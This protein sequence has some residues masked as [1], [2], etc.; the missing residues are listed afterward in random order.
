MT[1]PI[2]PTT[3]MSHA[4]RRAVALAAMSVA[5][6]AGACAKTQPPPQKPAVP[7]AIVTVRRTAVP[8]SVI[9][10]G[11]VAPMQTASVSSQVDGIITRVAFREGQDVDQGQVLFQVD[12]RPY[13]AAYN[14]SRANL[15]RD[16]AT[17]AYA[18]AEVA[19]Y[20]T[21]V[22]KDYVTKE[23]ADQQHATAA[24][25][26]ATLAADS[27]QLASAKFNFDNTSIRA[28]IAGRTGALL[29]RAGNL[30]HG[31]TGT[32]LVVI[33]QIRPILVQ[34]AV[35]A[36]SLPDI[37]RYSAAGTL[38]VAAYQ[39]AAESSNSS[40]SGSG[41]RARG[42][43]VAPP[44][45]GTVAPGRIG[46]QNAGAGAAG[47]RPRGGP[48]VLS[49]A[50]TGGTTGAATG[51]ATG[52]MAG[53]ASSS[54]QDGTSRIPPVQGAAGQASDQADTSG[55]ASDGTS[56]G[57]PGGGVTGA[58]TGTIAPAGPPID[59]TLSFINNAVDTATG[60]VLL[61]ATFP[62]TKGELWPGEYVATVL[63]LYVQQDALV[64]PT[65]AIMTGQQGTY[66]FVIDPQANTAKQRP[67]VIGR[68]SDTLA[69][70]SSG[71]AE[72][73][74][75]VIDGQSRLQNGAKVNVRAVSSGGQSS[76]R[77]SRSVS[78]PRLA[79]G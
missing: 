16:R 38:P 27:A 23:Q 73:E 40:D 5:A 30:V 24:S 33:N 3:S 67:V 4:R 62:N 56:G 44:P 50:A 77:G 69:V 14:Q 17:A 26:H 35:P 75:V 28:P 42:A 59:G 79:N 10:N 64:I 7:V 51:A 45:R 53:A 58:A 29:V 72:G 19:R 78:A 34:F 31:S 57:P 2:A 43:A 36:S 70:I 20:D 63:R 37:Q 68:T 71:L 13:A 39:A 25:A 6:V 32:P 65:Q 61:K 21:L 66:V 47:R 8:Y 22:A 54:R 11:T 46:T 60:T 55:A 76:A 9:A 74:R 18:A 41:D 1:I 15:E 48:P 12:P 52:A 49:G